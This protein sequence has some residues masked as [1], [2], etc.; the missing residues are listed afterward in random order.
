MT[1]EQPRVLV[2]SARNA[3]H[4]SDIVNRPDEYRLSI[5]ADPTGPVLDIYA[6]RPSP[7]RRT[8]SPT[9]R[10]KACATISTW[11]PGS[12]GRPAL[13]QVVLQQLGPVRGGVINSGAGLT[14]ALVV[15]LLIFTVCAA[16]V[17]CIARIRRG[18]AATDGI[19][20]PARG[21]S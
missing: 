5:Q 10:S 4:T 13:E 6:E 16:A 17:L 1:P 8:S 3:P 11:S 12:G 18:W 2:D 7:A 19:G 14:M 20:P 15:F 9:R 21:L